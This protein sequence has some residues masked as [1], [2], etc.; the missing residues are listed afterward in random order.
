MKKN[1]PIQ[2]TNLCSE[3][4]ERM[5]PNTHGR[6]C[7]N[8]QKQVHDL[9][10][11]STKEIL[12]LFEKNAGQLCGRLTET[13]L[14]LH[15]A[16]IEQQ[17][18]FRF[19]KISNAISAISVVA[20]A[21]VTMP[22]KKAN[23]ANCTTIEQP[24][25]FPV[26]SSPIPAL[27]PMDSTRTLKIGVFDER[28]EPII[29]ATIEI[30]DTLKKVIGG[31]VTDISGVGEIAIS[32]NTKYFIVAFFGK[33]TVRQ[34]IFEEDTEFRITLFD[35]YREIGEICGG[36]ISRKSIPLLKRIMSFPHHSYYNIKY[37]CVKAKSKMELKRKLRKQKRLKKAL[38]CGHTWHN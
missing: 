35:D 30:L 2:V 31:T 14:R 19:S 4:W 6:F 10:V 26:A 29:A 34:K 37:L 23:A 28:N 7:G 38:D 18:V 21:M 11:L 12:Q 20:M 33:E 22:L 1:K 36:L 16:A 17:Q 15:N 32:N 27:V 8:C 5:L 24:N 25:V 3:H 13:Q 9:T